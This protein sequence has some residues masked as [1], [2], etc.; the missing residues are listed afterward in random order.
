MDFHDCRHQMQMTSRLLTRARQS[1]IQNSSFLCKSCHSPP[2]RKSS[3]SLSLSFSLK[4]VIHVIPPYK[5]S[6]SLYSPHRLNLDSLCT[7]V[8][9]RVWTIIGVSTPK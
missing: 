9:L 8:M 5:L 7:D 6:S 1:L 3:S 2:F 4:R